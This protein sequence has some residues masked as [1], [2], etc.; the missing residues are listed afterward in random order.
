MTRY[1]TQWVLILAKCSQ[2]TISQQ[3]LIWKTIHKS[4]ESLQNNH[5]NYTLQLALS[6][7]LYIEK[8]QK[9]SQ[10]AITHLKALINYPYVRTARRLLGLSGWI[11]KQMKTN[12]RTNIM[13]LFCKGKVED[14]I[15]GE[16][17]S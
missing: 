10:V 13:F 4:Q 14:F 9:N 6:Y 11:S 17:N 1:E 12:Q 8:K 7:T 5:Q 3:Y 16:G 15:H 2:K